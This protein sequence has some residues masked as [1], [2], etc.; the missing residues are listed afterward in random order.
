MRINRLFSTALAVCLSVFAQ[1]QVVSVSESFDA[2][3]F[4]PA[5]WAIKANLG[6]Q[7]IWVRRTNGTNGTQVVC[8][9]HSGAGLARFTSRTVAA[10]TTQLL[11]TPVVDYSNREAMPLILVCGCFAIVYLPRIRILCASM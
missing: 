8:N 7:N 6:N 9:T 5:G 1:A 11:I 4:A 10:G 3:A 2:T